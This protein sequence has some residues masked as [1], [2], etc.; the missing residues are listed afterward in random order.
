MKVYSLLTEFDNG[1]DGVEST[2]IG[3]F[4]SLSEAEKGFN[5]IMP[6]IMA[7]LGAYEVRVYLLVSDLDAVPMNPKRICVYYRVDY[8]T[9]DPDDD[10][11]LI[12]W[13][14]EI[15]LNAKWPKEV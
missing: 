6:D 4:S 2:L 14:R 7:H 15:M 10:A 13:R 9:Y 8:D 3:V 5:H 12:E 1:C 11:S